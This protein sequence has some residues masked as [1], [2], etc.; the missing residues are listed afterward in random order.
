MNPTDRLPALVAAFVDM[1]DGPDAA[2]LL[3]EVVRHVRAVA[4]TYPDAYFALARKDD[5]SLDDLGNRVF[6]VCAAVPKGRFPFQGRAPFPAF[7]AE[8]MEG[9]AIRY[10]SFYAKLSI[11][12]EIM[13]DD[14]ARNI[15]RDPVLRWRADLYR[16]VGD[17][18]KALA[19][20][21][22]ATSERKGRGVPPTWQLA[23][24]GPRVIRPP[25]EVAVAL[26]R[27]LPAE[28]DALVRLALEAGG[29][30]TQ[31]RLT[32]LIETVVGTPPAADLEIEQVTPDLATAI[33]LRDAVKA[34]WDELDDADRS[35]LAALARGED[36]GT[37]VARDPR[38]KHKVA[39]TRA[40]GRIGKRFVTRILDDLGMES[41]AEAPPQ[42]LVEAVMEVL[43]EI[44]PAG[45]EGTVHPDDE[46]AP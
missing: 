6:T 23:R 22:A 46:E 27:R 43:E 18:L 4:R 8:H 28:I 26:K 24:S 34:A 33:A 1:P 14:Y 30:I 37:L 12:R 25:E 45:V 5:D 35:L 9:R 7:A 38:F 44:L 13:R 32:S 11:T 31:S 20:A 2:A 10:H 41:A 16:R 21:G 3:A 39:V 36:Y 15:V 19:E 17:A 40:V 29:P 42:R